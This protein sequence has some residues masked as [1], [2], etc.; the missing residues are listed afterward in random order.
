MTA[1]VAAPPEGIVIWRYL[2]YALAAL[3]V[4]RYPIAPA[5]LPAILLARA[6]GPAAAVFWNIRLPRVLAAAL[7][8]EHHLVH[9]RKET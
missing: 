4:G 8:G 9:G 3:A 5:E 7:V 6:E 1:T 2:W